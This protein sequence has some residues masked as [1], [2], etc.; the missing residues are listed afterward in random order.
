MI[1]FVGVLL[2]PSSSHALL[3]FNNYFESGMVLQRDVS[4]KI[5]GYG[6]ITSEEMIANCV[7]DGG[8]R[9][10][11][12]FSLQQV[13]EDVWEV[14]LDPREANTVCS[15]QVTDSDLVLD[16]VIIGDVWLCS[17]QSNMELNMDHIENA[18]EEIADSALYGDRIRFM[19]INH[20]WLNVSMDDYDPNIKISWTTADNSAKLKLMSAVCFLFAREISDK[21]GVPLGMVHASWGGTL[22]EAWS[23]PDALD[24]CD[25]PNH[26]GGPDNMQN[27]NSYLW[28]GMINPLKRNSL[29]GFLWYQ[30]EANSNRNRD[31]YNCMFPV[32]IDDWRNEFAAHSETLNTAPFG[33]VQLS[34]N[35]NPES[36]TNGFPVIRWHQTADV[37]VVPND[38]MP[39]VFMATALDTFDAADGYPGGIH[40]R[41]KQIVAQRLAIAGLNVAYGM[42]EYP[43]SG[44][45]PVDLKEDGG[46]VTFVYDQDLFMYDAEISGFYYCP[47]SPVKC[48]EGST[49]D[50]W[51]EVPKS[52]VLQIDQRTIVVNLTTFQ[53]VSTGSLGY[54]WRESPV[55]D[56][57]G[58]PIYATDRYSLP[59]P[60]W[61]M[62]ID[63]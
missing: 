54:L 23:D 12:V 53:P 58:L 38:L 50:L 20:Q 33:F 37:G 35:K 19:T 49:V 43:T 26:W 22:I 36:T 46:V 9:S 13:R 52:A 28:N 30:G 27:S 47:E 32:M 24:R 56:L 45:F 25:V 14:L 10:S 55:L 1:L 48:D 62:P 57:Y 18:E 5:W 60:P 15:I 34:T 44:P 40:P 29:K 59:S 17:G 16:D 21:I 51:A 42:E 3:K 31:L 39:D 4:T 8:H 2:L 6:T 63:N 61:K 7:D 11:S 41:Y